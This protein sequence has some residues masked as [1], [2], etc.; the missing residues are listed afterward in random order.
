MAGWQLGQTRTLLL[1][2]LRLP[3]LLHFLRALLL[4]QLLLLL[5][6]VAVAG[7]R[8]RRQ[9]LRTGTCRHGLSDLSDS[10]GDCCWSRNGRGGNLSF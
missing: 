2:L 8:K 5:L 10:C 4:L 9:Q 3:L 6:E 7:E 1:R